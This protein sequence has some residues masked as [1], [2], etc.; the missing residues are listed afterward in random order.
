MQQQADQPVGLEYSPKTAKK[1]RP[2]FHVPTVLLSTVCVAPVHFGAFL[3][4]AFLGYSCCSSNESTSA[5]AIAHVLG[6]PT[7]HLAWLLNPDQ[8]DGFLLMGLNSL[9]WGAVIG[10]GLSSLLGPPSEAAA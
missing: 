3:V 8:A 4:F 7:L 6:F 10:T 2:Y 9:V 1:W 5:N